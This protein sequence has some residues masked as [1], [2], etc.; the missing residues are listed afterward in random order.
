MGAAGRREDKAPLP[1][2][3]MGQYEAKQTW[4]QVGLERG[5]DDVVAMRR[6]VAEV[7][8]ES[9]WESSWY[10]ERSKMYVHS[11]VKTPAA[12]M[13]FRSSPAP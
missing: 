5:M 2:D 6:G 7:G 11:V 13:I 12:L 3:E 10:K 8:L 4:S 9:T 1:W